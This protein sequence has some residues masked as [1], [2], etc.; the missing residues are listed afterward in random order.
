MIF[1]RRAGVGCGGRLD[2]IPPHPVKNFPRNLATLLKVLRVTLRIGFILRPVNFGENVTQL[3]RTASTFTRQFSQRPRPIYMSHHGS[4]FPT[5]D[6]SDDECNK[7]A[8][9]KKQNIRLALTS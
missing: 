5:V 1:T 8:K 2:K 9:E 6:G 7:Q 3:L 4:V